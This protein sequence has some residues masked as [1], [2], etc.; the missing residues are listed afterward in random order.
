M[1]TIIYHVNDLLAA[2]ETYYE[3][4]DYLNAIDYFHSA[5]EKLESEGKIAFARTNGNPTTY[6]WAWA[7]LGW[8]HLT[9]GQTLDEL[10]LRQGDHYNQALYCLNR[11]IGVSSPMNR[12]DAPFIDAL[13]PSYLSNPNPD[14]PETSVLSNL[15]QLLPETQQ[16]KDEPSKQCRYAW[17]LAHRGEALRVI[18][19]K[20]SIPDKPKHY[21]EAIV[22]FWQAIELDPTYA[23]AYAHLGATIVNARGWCRLDAQDDETITTHERMHHYDFAMQYIDTALELKKHDYSWC[24]AYK[25]VLY[26]QEPGQHQQAFYAIISAIFQNPKLMNFKVAVRP[27][28][29]FGEE[30]EPGMLYA[31]STVEYLLAK[32]RDAKPYALMD[33]DTLNAYQAFYFAVRHTYRFWEIKLIDQQRA[34]SIAAVDPMTQAQAEAQ[35][36]SLNKPDRAYILGGLL[37]LKLKNTTMTESE[38]KKI[39]NE[40]LQHLRAAIETAHEIG[41]K[42]FADHFKAAARGDRAWYYL[43]DHEL[44]RQLTQHD[45]LL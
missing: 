32:T 41:G 1:A 35:K 38:R 36:L 45:E 11:A 26:L 4:R 40:A 37:A 17:A 10:D 25:G 19:N 42:P 33:A 24:L 13:S 21:Y 44:F 7:H 14:A 28:W 18:A 12:P 39:T 23:W 16:H 30:R 2:A 43:R 31:M 22:C 20:W 3:N 29:E 5:I 27:P 6:A 15:L 34:V 9:F 8:T